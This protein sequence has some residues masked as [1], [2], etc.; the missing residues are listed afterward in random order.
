MWRFRLFTTIYSFALR[1]HFI[2]GGIIVPVL[3]WKSCVLKYIPYNQSSTTFESFRNDVMISF[4]E[5]IDRR[6]LA[7][8]T[9]YYVVGEQPATDRT[10]ITFECFHKVIASFLKQNSTENPFIYFHNDNNSPQSSPGKPAADKNAMAP[11]KEDENISPAMDEENSVCTRRTGQ[12][13][14]SQG[15]KTRDGSACVFCD[16]KTHLEG[17]HIVS[18]EESKARQLTYEELE[19]F[20]ISGLMDVGNGLTLCHRCHK[21]FDSGFIAVN[22]KS[23]TIDVSGAVAGKDLQ[24]LQ[25]RSVS[26]RSRRGAWPSRELFEHRYAIFCQKRHQRNT[27]AAAKPYECD[28]CGRRFG[29]KTGLASH[30][31]SKKG[32]SK[33]TL[34]SSHLYT[35]DKKAGPG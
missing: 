17:A 16:A 24:S 32:C 27:N 18:L 1:F 28:N 30:R 35:P 22:P 15:L 2:T 4:A 8:C 25:G 14:F 29:S 31:K 21:A 9:L 20:R 33:A 3:S 5:E 6:K 23:M 19:K 11:V 12:T 34:P 10:R 26:K 7:Q 13:D